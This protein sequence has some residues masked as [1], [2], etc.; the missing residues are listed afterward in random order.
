MTS[1]D[2]TRAEAALPP[3]LASARL[4]RRIQALAIDVMVH[5]STLIVLMSVLELLGGRRPLAGA[6]LAGWLALVLVYE[7]LCVN[8]RGATLGHGLAG[9][10][11][12]D[13]E[14]GGPPDLARAFSRY[15]L[16]VSSGL[17]AVLF[18]AVSRDH[19]A[20]HDLAVGTLV[21]ERQ[22]P[23]TVRSGHG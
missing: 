15:W 17:V 19:Q 3:R 21:E 22:V 7:P 10:R 9:L 16:K 1:I 6:G 5:G 12:I 2:A 23:I 14:T 20:L 4:S 8:F 11:V 18:M 13:L